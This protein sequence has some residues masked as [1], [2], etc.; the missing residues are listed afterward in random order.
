MSIIQTSIVAFFL[1]L[2]CVIGIGLFRSIMNSSRQGVN[3]REDLLE[4]VQSVRMHKMLKALGINQQQYAYSHRVSDIEK[5]IYR[6][7]Q[8]A[9]TEQCDRE[10]ASGVLK[11]AE[12][13][14]PNNSDLLATPLKNTSA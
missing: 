3:F 8:C 5:H 4:R 13:Y 6:C 11:Q 2:A 10:L 1:L 12:S 14:C 7:K 9:N